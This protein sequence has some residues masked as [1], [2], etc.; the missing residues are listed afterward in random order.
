MIYKTTIGEAKKV[1]GENLQVGH[2]VFGSTYILSIDQDKDEI[3]FDVDHYSD[4]ENYSFIGKESEIYGDEFMIDGGEYRSYDLILD[5][6]NLHFGPISICDVSPAKMLSIIKT[7]I[8][9]MN[10]NGHNLELKGE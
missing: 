6:Y 1:F 7:M 10:G 9:Y 2:K 3:I 5:S 8:G 4:G